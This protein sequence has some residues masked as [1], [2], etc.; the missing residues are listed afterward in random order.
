[1]KK[2]KG[3]RGYMRARKTRLGVGTLVG[4]LYIL[5]DIIFLAQVKTM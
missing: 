3:E 4:F 5:S 1:M 2:K